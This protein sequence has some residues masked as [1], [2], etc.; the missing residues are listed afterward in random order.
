MKPMLIWLILICSLIPAETLDQ[1][2]TETGRLI[3][4]GRYK[5]AIKLFERELPE[6]R[7]LPP[8]MRSRVFNNIGFCFMQTKQY[9]KAEKYFALALEDDR[10]YI[11]CLNNMAALLIR[12]Q[13]YPDALSYLEHAFSLNGQEIK[14]VLNLCTVHY[15]MKNR[16]KMKFYLRLAYRIDK[17][18]TRSRLRKKGVPLK[19]LNI[20]EREFSE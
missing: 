14:V 13:H 20:I 9:T 18:Y 19:Y 2:L 16:E 8:N 3:D 6:I 17:E 5:K 11:R 7:E 10:D 4:D 12:R 1:T 15:R